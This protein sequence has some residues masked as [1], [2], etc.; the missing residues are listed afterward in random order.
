M[1][2]RHFIDSQ[3]IAEYLNFILRE[4]EGEDG[5]LPLKY[6]W[7]ICDSQKASL[8]EKHEAW[9]ELINTMTDIEISERPWLPAQKSLHEFLHRYMV[10]ERDMVERFT[11]ADDGTVYQYFIKYDDEDI[12]TGFDKVYRDFESCRN[13]AK[14]EETARGVKIVKSSI[15]DGP[16]LTAY[17]DAKIERLMSI[18]E[19]GEKDEETT[20]ILC[21]F[22]AMWFSFPTPFR[23]GDIVQLRSLNSDP[24]PFVLT[25][26]CTWTP[27]DSAWDS[28]NA[29]AKKRSAQH[30]ERWQKRGDVTDMFV[31]GFSLTKDG[32]IEEGHNNFSNY[33]KLEYYRGELI[34]YNRILQAVSSYMKGDTKLDRLLSAYR[35]ICKEEALA[36]NKEYLNWYTDESLAAAG[37]R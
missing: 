4:S 6:A 37:L 19:I 33:M 9:R 8:K 28:V 18:H 13:A 11:A 14:C 29:P 25:E 31:C 17:F 23:R 7:L 16:R 24:T 32:R 34:G 20:S 36:E 35:L 26:I 2:I 10:L 1:D 27:W 21:G 3:D 15:G 30:V 5:S 22:D 12:Y